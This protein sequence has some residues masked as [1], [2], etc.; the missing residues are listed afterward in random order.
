MHPL[1]TYAFAYCSMAAEE[2]LVLHQ[3]GF[4]NLDFKYQVCA[5]HSIVYSDTIIMN[6]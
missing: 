5:E 3:C 2:P 1:P 6:L 4:E